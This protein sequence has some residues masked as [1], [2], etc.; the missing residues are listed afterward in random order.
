[1]ILYDLREAFNLLTGGCIL[2]INEII[3]KART[4]DNEDLYFELKQTQAYIK[5]NGKYRMRPLH[6]AI[7]SF[8]NREGGRII[9]GIMDNGNPE[10]IGVFDLLA[11]ASHSGIDKFKGAVISSTRSKISPPLD[12]TINHH[13]NDEYEF[14]EIIIP[15]RKGMP[16]A[17]IEG[18]PGRVRDRLYYIRTSNSKE[19]VSDTQL[20]WM[21]SGQSFNTDE[22]NILIHTTTYKNIGGVPLNG[23]FHVDKYILQPNGTRGL[24][25]FIHAL[26]DDSYERCKSDL[27]YKIE[28]MTEM[29]MYSILQ[30]IEGMSRVV[31]QDAKAV[32][33]P[34]E[35]FKLHDAI[36]GKE[37][38]LFNR[39]DK[40]ISFPPDS[41][42]Q[43]SKG[44]T[45]RSVNFLIR[46][47]YVSI[48]LCLRFSQWKPGL[49]GSNPYAWVLLQNHGIKGQSYLEENY[50]S[51]EY[52]L[53]TKIS[54]LFPDIMSKEYYE[55]YDYASNFVQRLRGIWDINYFLEEFPHYRKAYSIEHKID[56]LTDLLKQNAING[57]SE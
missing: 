44:E 15:K 21:F 32:P 22:N 29:M 49:L 20:A 40:C 10:G 51:F 26:S 38:E 19:L 45:E 57:T 8:A 56:A 48:E 55:S 54:R 24:Q 9:I 35:D 1:M 52:I 4:E 31:S 46:N 41:T 50:E 43:I 14:V 2:N 6:E 5:P 34:S 42:L 7:V 12:L 47:D 16:H 11:D 25:P 3:S 23:G 30:T 18:E 36:L 13:L 28:L 39:F 33:V 53:K 37:E 27:D 17:V